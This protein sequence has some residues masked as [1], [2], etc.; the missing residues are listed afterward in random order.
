[1][2]STKYVK[3]FLPDLIE[4]LINKGYSFATFNKNDKNYYKN[5]GELVN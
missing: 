2:H 3:V 4:K 5:Y 1:M